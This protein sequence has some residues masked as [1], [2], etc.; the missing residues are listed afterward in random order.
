MSS[1]SALLRGDG[2]NAAPRVHF[3]HQ[4]KACGP[5]ADCVWVLNLHEPPVRSHALAR[6]KK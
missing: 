1:K 5:L 2:V 3:S 6:M 4:L